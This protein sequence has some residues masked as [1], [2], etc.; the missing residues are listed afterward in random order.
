MKDRRSGTKGVPFNG[1][2]TTLG[3]SATVLHVFPHDYF[4]ADNSFI[5][6]QREIILRV[7]NARELSLSLSLRFVFMGISMD[8]Q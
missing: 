4:S 1:I 6:H 3:K 2:V 8:F 7:D 5:S